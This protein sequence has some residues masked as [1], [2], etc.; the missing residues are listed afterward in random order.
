M[1]LIREITGIVK[2]NASLDCDPESNE[3]NLRQQI[4][5]ILLKRVLLS[6]KVTKCDGS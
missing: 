3:R 6:R 4:N 5:T 2:A 1:T